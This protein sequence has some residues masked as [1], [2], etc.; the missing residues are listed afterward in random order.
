MEV[1]QGTLAGA[2][3]IVDGDSMPALGDEAC[4]RVLVQI[5]PC[6]GD[7]RCPLAPDMDEMRLAATRRTVQHERSGRP[8]GPPVDPSDANR[9]AV[10]NEKIRAAQRGAAGQV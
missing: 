9:V 1:E 4:Y 2:I 8:I 10:R 7:R 6:D 3:G 5:E